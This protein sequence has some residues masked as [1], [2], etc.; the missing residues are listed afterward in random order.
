MRLWDWIELIINL[1]L[2]MFFAGY[3]ILLVL[4]YCGIITVK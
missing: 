4:Q 1:L 3:A 2:G